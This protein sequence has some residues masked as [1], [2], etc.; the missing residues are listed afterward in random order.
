MSCFN[1]LEYKNAKISSHLYFPPIGYCLAYQQP[2]DLIRHG[3]NFFE[4]CILILIK[5]QSKTLRLLPRLIACMNNYSIIKF[6]F[7]NYFHELHKWCSALDLLSPQTI[8]SCFFPRLIGHTLQPI[9]S[10]IQA[11][12]IEAY[13]H[14]V[15]ILSK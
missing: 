3:Y 13:L 2:I 12:Q 14:Y 15:S 7:L 10:I 11:H 6:S 4:L 9:L 8:R 5:K 1:F